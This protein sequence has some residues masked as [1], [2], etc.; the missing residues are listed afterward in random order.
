MLS[1]SHHLA[2][3]TAAATAARNVARPGRCRLARTRVAAVAAA[4][5]LAAA[6]STE[7]PPA[8][9]AAEGTTT[10]VAAAPTDTVEPAV[11]AAAAVT[12]PCNDPAAENLG[13]G[14]VE[15]DGVVF[16]V[17]ADACVPRHEEPA[18]DDDAPVQ[19][20]PSSTT[21]TVAE[22][23]P[24]P[25]VTAQE[26]EWG[27]AKTDDP[28]AV[29]DPVAVEEAGQTIAEPEPE[30]IPELVTT[31]TAAPEPEPEQPEPEPEP[32][33]EPE[34]EQPEP[35]PEPEQPEPEPEPEAS[36]PDCVPRTVLDAPCIDRNGVEQS[37]Q[38]QLNESFGGGYIGADWYMDTLSTIGDHPRDH[39]AATH[40]VTVHDSDW[41]ANAL[42][43]PAILEAVHPAARGGQPQPMP[44][45]YH[46]HLPP[47]TP[48]VQAWSD[49]CFF[50]FE[51]T[52]NWPD[53]V[54]PPSDST[55]FCSVVLHQM[56]FHLSHLGASEDCILPQAT[57]KIEAAE[58]R[59]LSSFTPSGSPERAASAALSVATNHLHCPNVIYPDPDAVVT[60]EDH[61]A[62]VVLYGG[63][64][65]TSFADFAASVRS[66]AGDG[67]PSQLLLRMKAIGRIPNFTAGT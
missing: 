48:A 60:L 6:C 37:V 38:S 36:L 53:D 4:A 55:Y 26:G 41:Q 57:A 7:E 50:D 62:L 3:T 19:N 59:A 23:E 18:S 49:W 64:A 11:T 45:H 2:R 56:A 39:H 22:P 13:D 16:E 28:V 32:T 54:L 65:S 12:S 52:V 24:T 31:T 30:P 42:G 20:T 25:A 10:T 34:P 63:Q 46:G 51:M 9:P 44:G 1:Q 67:S 33:P 43:D 47:F 29:V 35:T 8:Q 61:Y 40:R 21:T 5:L 17:Y 14:L 66:L 15:L 27:G 58:Q